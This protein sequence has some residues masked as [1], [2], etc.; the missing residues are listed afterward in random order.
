MAKPSLLMV[1]DDTLIQDLIG[2]RLCD[3]FDIV[4]AHNMAEVKSAM[5]QMSA[6]PDYAL[7]DLGLP[8]TPHRP[9][10]GFAVVRLLQAASSDCAIVVVSGQEARRH[11]QRA[12]ALGAGEYVEKPCSPELLREKLLSCRALLQRVRRSLGLVGESPPMKRLRADIIQIA[13]LPLPVLIVGETGTGKELAARALHQH[14]RPGKPFLP[15]NCAAIPDH[16][17]EPTLFGYG[18][19]AFTGAG[20]ASGGLLGDAEDGT[21]FLDEIS[22]LSP[23]TQ[24][25]LLRAIETGEYNRVG[26]TRPRQCAA[27]VVA[28]TNRTSEDDGMRRDLYHRISAFTLRT[29]SLRD[30]GDDRLLLLEHFRT[31]IAADMQGEPFALSA[32]AAGRWHEYQFPGNI[33]EL[34]NIT[35]RLQVKY[36]GG[37]VDEQAVMA[38]FCPDDAAVD[39]TRALQTHRL[40]ETLVRNG[41][42]SLPAA[43]AELSEAAARLALSQS[44]GDETRAAA[45][46]RLPVDELRRCLRPPEKFS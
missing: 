18:K 13:K 33:R 10:E 39:L 25:K 44:A 21:L 31:D 12:R 9:D 17:A 26:E 3:E 35:A 8:P 27:R 11:A 41:G 14:D 36:S 34:R 45:L 23:P 15:I 40:A 2:A 43:L 7:V 28:A 32:A 42:E 38:E 22:D 6:P 46:L 4:G 1:D 19:G 37:E 16:L 5:Q 20:T 29:P 24:G 30:M